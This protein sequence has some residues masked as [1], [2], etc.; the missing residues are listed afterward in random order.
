MNILMILSKLITEVK[1][2]CMIMSNEIRIK[3]RGK[4]IRITET[5]TFI[6][7]LEETN[8]KLSVAVYSNDGNEL[9]NNVDRILIE[10]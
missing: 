1:E 5:A 8:K 2:G 7:I 3:K 10:L 9:I 4:S 6:E